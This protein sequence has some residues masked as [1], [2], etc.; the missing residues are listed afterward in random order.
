MPSVQDVVDVIEDLAPPENALSFDRIG[1]QLGDP[2]RAVSSA[3][4]ALDPT[5]GM[6]AFAKAHHA[7]IAICHHPIIW[8]PLRAIREDE[9][10]GRLI[11]SLVRSGIAFYAA[12][13]HWDAATGGV[14]DTLAEKLGLAGVEPFGGASGI[15]GYKIAVFTPA[16]AAQSIIDAMSKAGAGKI[17]L[18]ARCAFWTAGTGTFLGGEGSNPATG[19]AGAI[20]EVDELRVEM[21]A[22]LDVLEKVLGALRL[23]HPYEEPAFDV[24]PLRTESGTPL[25]RVGTLA[26]PCA[27]SELRLSVDTAL[28]TRCHAWGE[29][30]LRV[31]RVAV[32]GGASDSMWRAAQSAGADVL[33]TGEVK[34][35]VA[36]EAVESGFAVIAAGH[37]ATE[38]PAMVR[39]AE[40]LRARLQDVRWHVYEPRPGADGRPLKRQKW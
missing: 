18:Y 19:N 28:S 4:L 35:N 37:Y 13:T 14:S 24:Y 39:L 26:E 31:A 5:G 15:D 27:L 2:S 21:R 1:L 22:G 16:S 7:E 25:G 30:G 34:Q 23:A 3:V 32:A 36:V 10:Q 17:G 33:V 9:P 38:M 11:A 8:D 29:A 20:E 12:H 6:A 40:L